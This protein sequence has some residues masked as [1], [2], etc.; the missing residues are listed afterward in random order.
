MDVFAGALEELAKA[1]P[2][3]IISVGVLVIYHFM[4]KSNIATYKDIYTKSIEE[5]RL[6]Y[7]KSYQQL[8]QFQMK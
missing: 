5:I 1:S 8:S 7:E 6:S 4:Y 3:A 2:Y